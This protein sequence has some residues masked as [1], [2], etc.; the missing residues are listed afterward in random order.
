VVRA[1]AL[2]FVAPVVLAACGNILSLKD[3]QPYPAEGGAEGGGDDASDEGIVPTDAAADGVV[4]GDGS[5]PPGDG[6]TDSNVLDAHGDQSSPPDAPGTDA[7]VETGGMD[8]PAD[9]IEELPPAD[10]AGCMT[11]D[12]LCGT[13]CV[14][15]QNDNQ[16]CGSCGHSCAG[17]K[18][19][20]GVCQPLQIATEV[21]YDIVIAQSKAY[22]VDESTHVYS[23]STT[24]VGMCGATS[25]ATGQTTERIA[26]DGVGNIF[27]TNQTGGSIGEYVIASNTASTPVTGLAAPQGIAA[28]GTDLFFTDTSLEEIVRYP[29][30]SGPSQPVATGSSSAPAGVTI[31]GTN[32]YFVDDGTGVV[33]LIP[34]TSWSSAGMRTLKSGES[35]PW[36]IAVSG[37]LVYWVNYPITS[38]GSVN[39]VD[40][41][42]GTTTGPF[43]TPVSPIR[44]VTDGTAIYWTDQ[45]AIG[46]ANGSVV[47]CAMPCASPVLLVQGLA[48]PVGLAV[49]GNV[50]YYGVTKG[51]APG[52]YRIAL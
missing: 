4:T 29:L 3:L 28:D 31:D 48:E 21:A 33:G 27:W 24:G 35:F 23:C 51:V 15:E 44:I 52:V 42:S 43:G 17:G 18:C 12:T 50:V 37:S 38:N 46:M 9:V 10:A 49:D 11:G 40:S 7:P 1:R 39:A 25:I 6:A 2:A 14:N 5:R 8:A 36:S 19:Q 41:T 32:A 22:W 47:R 45:G 30:P 34:F 20:S 16:N 26:Y 13:S